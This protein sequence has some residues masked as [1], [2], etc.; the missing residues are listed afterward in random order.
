MLQWWNEALELIT[1]LG[2]KRDQ[3]EVLVKEA[4]IGLRYFQY[5]L[6]YFSLI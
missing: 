3:L 4:N 6:Q 1:E 5:G 2:I